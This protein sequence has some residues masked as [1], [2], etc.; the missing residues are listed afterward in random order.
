MKKLD[1]LNS[2]IFLT[3]TEH[4]Q[5]NYHLLIAYCVKH[6]VKHFTSPFNPHTTQR[7]LLPPFPKRIRE[8]NLLK[9]CK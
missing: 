1:Q 3:G 8:R 9:K 5:E 7:L 2:Y 6:Y 4:H